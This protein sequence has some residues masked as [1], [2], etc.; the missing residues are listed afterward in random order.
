MAR[1]YVWHRESAKAFDTVFTG[2]VPQV[3]FDEPFS[4][5]L[6]PPYTT[7]RYLFSATTGLRAARVNEPIALTTPQLHECFVTV[8]FLGPVQPTADDRILE[9]M[10][11]PAGL[12]VVPTISTFNNEQLWTW[13]THFTAQDVQ[14][15]RLWT[16]EAPTV[17]VT[18][19]W[20]HLAFDRNT[21]ASA[22]DY[23]VNT[24]FGASWNLR[25]LLSQPA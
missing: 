10:M 15:Q 22:D 18:F 25:T 16:T 8:R 9:T 4:P 5:I 23:A 3:V 17:R 11:Q 7:H 12:A 19:G 13:Q 1:N 24:I 6:L 2:N 21:L 14:G 20:S